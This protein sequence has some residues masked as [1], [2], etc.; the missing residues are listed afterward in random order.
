MSISKVTEKPKR[1]IYVDKKPHKAKDVC[2]VFRNNI[3]DTLDLTKYWF[4][5]LSA[6]AFYFQEGCTPTFQTPIEKYLLRKTSIWCFYETTREANKDELEH[7]CIQSNG[8]PSLSG[9]TRVDILVVKEILNVKMTNE[10]RAAY[11]FL[12][13]DICSKINEWNN[14]K[15]YIDSAFESGD[16]SSFSQNIF[17]EAIESGWFDRVP[18]Y[19][20]S[21]KFLEKEYKYDP[22]PEPDYTD[23]LP[24]DDDELIVVDA[25]NGEE[26]KEEE[27][28]KAKEKYELPKKFM[29]LKVI[30]ENKKDDKKTGKPKKSEK[31]KEINDEELISMATDVVNELAPAGDSEKFINSIINDGSRDVFVSSILDIAKGL[32]KSAISLDFEGFKKKAE[33][34]DTD[35]VKVTSYGF[36]NVATLINILL[37]GAK[38]FRN[39]KDID[40]A[41]NIINSVVKKIMEIFEEDEDF[42]NDLKKLLKK[43]ANK[44]A[45]KTEVKENAS[46]QLKVEPVKE[47]KPAAKKEVKKEKTHNAE[48]VA[49]MDIS[50]SFPAIASVMG[51]SKNDEEIPSFCRV[52]DNNEPMRSET[53]SFIVDA[54]VQQPMYYNPPKQI[55]ATYY[56]EAGVEE[57]YPFIR[58]I[59]LIGID[60]N[61]SLNVLGIRSG[62]K[63]LAIQFCAY[64]SGNWNWLKSF[65]ID[66]GTIIDDRT[67]VF[68]NGFQTGFGFMEN[69][70]AAYAVFSKEGEL[71][72]EFFKQI[73]TV[74]TTGLDS[75]TINQYRM[76]NSNMM[77]LNRIIDRRS[78]NEQL[79][80]IGNQNRNA[81]KD[82]LFKMMR[83]IKDL[84]IENHIDFGRFRVSDFD[85]ENLHYDLSN[86]DMGYCDR[87]NRGPRAIFSVDI[88]KDKDGNPVYNGKKTNDIKLTFYIKFVDNVFDASKLVYP[89]YATTVTVDSD[90]NKEDVVVEG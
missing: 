74:G 35:A 39:A 61:V 59:A 70:N 71:N 40:D 88:M 76:F 85:G 75:K 3:A 87:P 9:I 80:K 72:K 26:K 23:D 27:K 78:I 29:G 25:D 86:I 67:K 89:D 52:D 42:I 36:S 37:D 46:E 1:G 58:D 4:M 62:D 55:A 49:A 64:T 56:I 53:P 90:D 82:S 77:Q 7:L 41:I 63:L 32:I 19:D 69:C 48:N 12:R 30:D 24:K 54:N 17:K 57:Q 60:Q 8:L 45:K 73:F 44:M 6:T 11:E 34:I 15:A 79:G 65:T 83:I 21:G 28:P 38:E 68:F 66:L 84:S 47:E 14:N 43:V 81:V 22:E 50:K 33:E 20:N 13:K 2:P 5:Q 31:V 10:E 51:Q 16:Y 18:G